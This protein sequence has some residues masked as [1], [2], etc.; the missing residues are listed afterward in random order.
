MG[1]GSAPHNGRGSACQCV[2]AQ[3]LRKIRYKS[4]NSS[5]WDDTSAN[6]RGGVSFQKLFASFFHLAAA[7]TSNGQFPAVQ[8][9]KD[10]ADDGSPYL[11]SRLD[12]E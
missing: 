10:P 12:Q 4:Q 7:A 5:E 3:W 2:F 11:V 1:G 6:T 8:K 9:L